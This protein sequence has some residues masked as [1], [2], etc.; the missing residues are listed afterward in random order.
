MKYS[1]FFAVFMLS[2]L[3]SAQDARLATQYYTDG[4]F[5]KALVMFQQLYQKNPGNEYYFKFYLNCLQSLN[6]NDEAEELLKKEIQNR[7]KDCQLHILYAN[8]LNKRNQ[9]DKAEKQFKLAIEKL[10]PDVIV[11]H[12]V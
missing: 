3:L 5:E 4:E 8:L 1:L 11:V 12:N 10:P 9:T 7:P 6:K 2:F